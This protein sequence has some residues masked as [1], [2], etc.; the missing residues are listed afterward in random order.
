MRNK[1]IHDGFLDLNP[2]IYELRENGK[3]KE[4]F[5]LLPDLNSAGKF[6]KIWI[7]K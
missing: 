4:R 6:E 3:V 1:I 5:I 2:Q 7:K